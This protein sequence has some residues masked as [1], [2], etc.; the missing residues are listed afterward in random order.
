M[1]KFFILVACL[2]F[3]GCA[4]MQIAPEREMSYQKTYDIPNMSKSAI[5]DKA[6][7]WMAETFVSSKRVIELKDKENGKIIGNG[8]TSIH[9]GLGVYSDYGYTMII[10]TKDNR[11]KL[12]YK[13]LQHVDGT[14]ILAGRLKKVK[15][16]L[17]ALS[18]DL[19]NYL[20]TQ[21]KSDW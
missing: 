4:G 2:F 8:I 18:N 5:Y 1:R 6:L 10:D 19:Y 15:L 7:F 17:E 13:N 20:L 9:A 14:G 16:K 21:E 12:T 3:I 11:V